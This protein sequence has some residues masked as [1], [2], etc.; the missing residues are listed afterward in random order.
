MELKNIDLEDIEDLL[1]KIERS[2]GF[3]FYNTELIGI[4]TFGDL[5]DVITAKVQG[6]NVIDCTTQ[7]GFYKLRS[8]IVAT[9]LID[10][11]LIGPSTNLEQVF[12]RESRRRRIKDLQDELGFPI[13]ILGVKQWV[14]W[15]WFIGL[16]ASLITFF[17]SWLLALCALAFFLAFGWVANKFFAKELLVS[18]VG[19]LSEKLTRENYRK[20]RRKSSTVNRD[21]IAQVVKEIFNNEFDLEEELLTRQTRFR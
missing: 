14:A 13:V 20:A 1:P 11:N 4:Q 16:I 2:F 18:T 19:E 9:Q 3:Q 10:K 12:P 6:D 17:F 7:Q 21:E 15:V 5:C 8:A